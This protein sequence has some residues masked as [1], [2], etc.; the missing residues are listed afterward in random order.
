VWHRDAA[1]EQL[2]IS[3]DRGIVIVVVDQK[4]LERVGVIE[5]IL[6]EA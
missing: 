1:L 6:G 2:K 4:D 5:R 3:Q